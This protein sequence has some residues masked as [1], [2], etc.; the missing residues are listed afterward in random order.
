MQYKAYLLGKLLRKYENSKAF[1]AP[2]AARRVLIHPQ[3]DSSLEKRME[4]ADEKDA[5]LAALQSLA[6]QK[7]LFFEWQKFEEGN[8]VDRKSVV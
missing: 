7:L 5:F 6:R 8:L 3:E 1:R 4:N 2:D